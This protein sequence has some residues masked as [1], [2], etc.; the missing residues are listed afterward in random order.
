MNI[1]TRDRS[2]VK[3]QRR[4][5]GLARWVTGVFAVAACAAC[6]EPASA[7]EAP[8]ASTTP[9]IPMPLGVD[10]AGSA[11]PLFNDSREQQVFEDIGFDFLSYHLG[12]MALASEVAQLDA[13][14]RKTG[15]DYI[16]NNEGG[17]RE[18]G[19]AKLYRKPGLFFQFP[20]DLVEVCRSSPHFLGICYDELDHGIMNGAW[21]TILDNK[22]AP[23]FY[24][25][26]GDTLQQAY[27]SNVHNVGVLMDT[28]YPGFAA[29]ARQPGKRPIVCGEYVFPVL[30]HLL[31]RGGIVPAPKYLKESMT[32]VTA[33]V[34]L[35]A[36]KQY[37]LP[38]WPCLDLWG[39]TYPGHSPQELWSS[40]LFSYWTGAERAYVENLGCDGTNVLYKG[41][42]YVKAAK[43][44][45][46]SPWGEVVKAFKRD[47]MPQHPRNVSS[48][49]FN[50]E[51]VIVRFEDSDW[52]QEKTGNWISGYLYGVPDLKP[53]PET[54]YWFKI[55]NVISHGTTPLGALNYNTLSLGQP[56]RF[57]FPA[58]NVAVYDHLASDPDL[59]RTARLVFLSGKM[60]SPECMATLSRLVDQNGLTVVTPPRL[61][62]ADMQA[63]AAA[64]CAVVEQGKG[65]WIL[66]D[67][68]TH[69]NVVALLKPYLG[70]PDEMR[71]TFGTTD[72]VFTAPH[73]AEPIRVDVKTPGRMGG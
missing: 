39:S 72:V 15:H 21:I 8:A 58:N 17:Q 19:D 41:S 31:A 14:A 4:L 28:Q 55:W 16:L 47:Y 6:L 37:G 7:E 62:P 60:V 67:D 53:D 30:N 35:G 56:Y 34:A 32:P 54:R 48:R 61:A 66:T 42:L 64:P 57:F 38:Y 20:K 13:W 18:Q 23:Y 10:D 59:Y 52:G 63:R 22:Y 3:G 36:A 68:V 43:G 27:E 73:P 26:S 24:D 33:A 25:A 44:V 5:R 40:L 29:N 69:E 51:I 45:V 9:G 65:R 46:L 12:R 2:S 11:I 1:D 71:F 50:P 49:E 70:R